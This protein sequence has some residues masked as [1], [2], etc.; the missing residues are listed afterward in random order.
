MFFVNRLPAQTMFAPSRT[1]SGQESK[2]IPSGT[3]HA[4]I[5]PDDNPEKFV[6]T[7]NNP[8]SLKINISVE[9][10]AAGY[11][12]RTSETFFRKRF[13]MTGTEDGEYAVLVSDGINVFSKKVVVQTNTEVTRQVVLK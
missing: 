11:Q 9:G 6:L 1:G 7:I 2:V 12:S 13:D 5:T 10:G 3:F 8:H 4:E